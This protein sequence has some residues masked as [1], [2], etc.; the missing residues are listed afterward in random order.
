MLTNEL[1]KLI[2][3][4]VI[5]IL[6]GLSMVS[7]SDSTS[8][9]RESVVKL[10]SVADW[11]RNA[12][13]DYIV[14]QLNDFGDGLPRGYYIKP[15]TKDSLFRQ[16]GRPYKEQGKGGSHYLYWKCSDGQIQLEVVGAPYWH[17]E[18]IICRGVN[19]Y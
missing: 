13:W 6:P 10:Q 3:L 5:A 2:T 11:K 17:Q 19:I 7:C 1:V 18:N 14:A 16:V 12:G 9:P 8:I 15:T 4:A